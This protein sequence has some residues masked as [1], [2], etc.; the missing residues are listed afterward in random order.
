MARVIRRR[1]IVA[2]VMSLFAAILLGCS[3][4]DNPSTV[5]GASTQRN[6]ATSYEDYFNNEVE[7]WLN[8]HQ[9]E[10]DDNVFISYNPQGNNS[11]YPSTNYIYADFIKSLHSMSVDGVGGGDDMIYFYTGQ[12]DDPQ[13]LVHGMVNIAAFL[14]HAMSLPSIKYDLCDEYNVDNTDNTQKYAISNSCGQY[15]RSYQDEVCIG[16]DSYMTCN[17]NTNM[18]MVAVD[19]LRGDKS[20]P[21]F[22][23]RPRDNPNDFTGHWDASLG[24]LSDEFPYSNRHGALHNEGCCWWGRGVLLTRGICNMGRINNYLGRNAAE[25]GYENFFDLDIC[26][27]PEVICEGEDTR[28]L[29]WS[30]G[31]F[32]WADRVQTF[33]NTAA[34]AASYM[35][36]LD[37]FVDSGFLDVNSFIDIVGE[38]LPFGC[39]ESNC[40]AEEEQVKQDRRDHFTN[41]VFNVLDIPSLVGTTSRP[42][43]KKMQP[44]TEQPVETTIVTPPPTIKSMASNPTN[45]PSTIK[46]TPQLSTAKPTNQPATINLTP[47]PIDVLNPPTSQ[48]QSVDPICSGLPAGTTMVPI[49]ECKDFV[50]CVNGNKV[51]ELSCG[52]GLLYDAALGSCN[53]EFTVSCNDAP[54]P[55]IMKPT[56]QTTLNPANFPS[57]NP[58]STLIAPPTG[59]STIDINSSGQNQQTSNMPTDEGLINLPSGASSVGANWFVRILCPKNLIV[60]SILSVLW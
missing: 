19:S 32:E 48:T 42:T 28:E 11:P 18:A 54:S 55:A 17:A 31:Y 12:T 22:E 7:Q 37:A 47:Q 60:L 57:M 15:G 39:F 16:K 3:H 43:T 40:F 33:Q 46:P 45:Q 10:L 6:L 56:Q 44:T 36:A 53:L 27:Y 1:P 20:P 2:A 13:S 23:C 49:N 4:D 38:A 59:P 58:P 8:T 24:V 5:V 41:L 29:R 35:V 26:F 51:S 14:S 52:T 21:P 25:Q 50:E 30:V 9:N 34:D